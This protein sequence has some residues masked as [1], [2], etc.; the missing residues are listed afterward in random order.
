ML[1]VYE[2]HAIRYGHLDRTATHNFIGGDL[3]DGP[4]PLDYFVWLIR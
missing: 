2:I 3:H 4:M 1:S